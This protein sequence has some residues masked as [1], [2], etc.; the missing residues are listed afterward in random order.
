M[1]NKYIMT[2]LISTLLSGCSAFDNN[3]GINW[4]SGTCPE[5]STDDI[6]ASGHLKIMDGRTLKCQLRPYV[7]KM[8]CQGITDST[9]ADGIVCQDASGKGMLF[10]FDDNGVLKGHKSLQN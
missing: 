9:N 7:S 4:G 8:A 1:Q 5:P 3:H 6:A 2:I 10:I